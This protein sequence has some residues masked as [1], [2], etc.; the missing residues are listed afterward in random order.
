MRQG[1]NNRRSRGRGSRRPHAS[2]R[3]QTYDSNG[4][5]IRI[6]GNAYQ[7]LEKYLAMARD[8]ASAGDRIAAE[9]FYQH[10]EHYYRII[11]ANGGGDQAGPNGRHRPLPRPDGQD[12]V[13]FDGQADG[14]EGNEAAAN[15]S[16]HPNPADD[17]EPAG[18]PEDSA[19]A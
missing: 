15:Q 17:D 10:A 16:R 2:P 1:P 3:Q 4:P 9:N 5:D 8:A 7:V 19:D 11:N 14:A 6:R 18:G 12:V 13:A